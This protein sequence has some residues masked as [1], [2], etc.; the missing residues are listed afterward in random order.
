[1]T[2]P[3]SA[4]RP[5]VPADGRKMKMP[6]KTARARNMDAPTAAPPTSS[7]SSSGSEWVAEIPRARMPSASESNSVNTPRII[8]HFSHGR[9][10]GAVVVGRHS[11][12]MS[13]AGRRTATAHRSRP[14][15]ITPSMTACPP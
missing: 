10:C 5:F 7:R 6:T 13:P 11:S 14:R 1:M 9:R 2:C 8:G 12:Q 3:M 15:I 4:S